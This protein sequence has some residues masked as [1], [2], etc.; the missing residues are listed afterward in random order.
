MKKEEK[1][2]NEKNK[3]KSHLLKYELILTNPTLLQVGIF[4]A[5]LFSHPQSD[6]KTDIVDSP[7]DLE[8]SL[9]VS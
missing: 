1:N 5:K 3:R 2:R 6:W 7:E 4:P 8:P 9:R